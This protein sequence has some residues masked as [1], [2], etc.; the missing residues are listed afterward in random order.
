M[1]ISFAQLHRIRK[2]T[3]V[4]RVIISFVFRE[5]ISSF[6]SFYA[7]KN[8]ICLFNDSILT[9]TL[10]GHR[11]VKGQKNQKLKGELKDMTRKIV[12]RA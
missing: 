8:R 6:G 9:R 11:K 12:E 3:P 4:L 2:T 7:F 10:P 1:H 5:D